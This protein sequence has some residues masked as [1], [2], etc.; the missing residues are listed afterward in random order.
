MFCCENLEFGVF[1]GVKKSGI[2]VFLVPAENGAGVNK[3]TNITYACSSV[4]FH[5]PITA[6]LAHGYGNI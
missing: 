5:S 6:I 4:V 1:V 2:G 3:L